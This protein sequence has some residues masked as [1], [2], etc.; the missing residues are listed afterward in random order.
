MHIFLSSFPFIHTILFFPRRRPCRRSNTSNHTV[1]LVT[2]QYSPF[3][4]FLLPFIHR[5]SPLK[6]NALIFILVRAVQQEQLQHPSN[7]LTNVVLHIS[8]TANNLFSTLYH[9]PYTRRPSTTIPYRRLP[10][11]I[12]Y[13]SLITPHQQP[14][15]PPL[16]RPYKNYMK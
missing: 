6:N 15:F 1:P 8:T 4:R 9:P 13:Q 5:R 12:L 2:L 10:S 14:I 3:I 16:F 11:I 7:P